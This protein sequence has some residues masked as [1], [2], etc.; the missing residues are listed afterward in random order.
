MN[1][2]ITQLQQKIQSFIDSHRALAEQV[3]MLPLAAHLFQ[4]KYE[5][6][7]FYFDQLEQSLE[8]LLQAEQQNSANAL[9]FYS[10]RLSAQFAALADV[11]NRMQW[12]QKGQ[13]KRV[14]EPAAQYA[15]P[16]A[17]SVHTL[18]WRERLAK[19][20]EYLREFNQLV[21]QQ[22]DRLRLAAESER[23]AQQQRL[24]KL[25]ERRAK[26]LDAIET[27]EAYS[28]FKQKQEDK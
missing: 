8:K 7:R 2:L 17:N 26:C 22:E 1:P 28:E 27:L 18:P 11:V 14:K 23:I 25:I 13:E 12:Q 6:L 16:A 20:Y 10:E 15:S 24:Q 21:E 3:V 4:G 9:A 5:P 19:Y